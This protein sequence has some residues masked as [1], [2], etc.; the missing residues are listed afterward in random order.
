MC[1]LTQARVP[2][3]PSNSPACCLSESLSA[4]ANCTDHF[5]GCTSRF[6]THCRQVATER[7]LCTPQITSWVFILFS[8]Q[9]SLST[10]TCTCT[11]STAATVCA[12]NSLSQVSASDPA[13][14]R[15]QKQ[16]CASSSGRGAPTMWS[17]CPLPRAKTTLQA[18]PEEQTAM[19]TGGGT[20]TRQWSQSSV[21]TLAVSSSV[22]EL[23]QYQQ[24]RPNIQVVGAKLGKPCILWTGDLLH[25]KVWA[26]IR[27]HICCSCH[28][29]FA[30]L[31]AVEAWERPNWYTD[32]RL[33]STA[34]AKILRKRLET[35]GPQS[36]LPATSSQSQSCFL[37]PFLQLQQWALNQETIQDNDR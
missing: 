36:K 15:V 25:T 19:L 17:T 5:Q 4:R 1:L 37:D 34:A 3:I 30:L 31:G 2:C 11:P 18:A 21:R 13:P 20:T 24:D 33:S 27:K 6:W 23:Q 10:A 28:S 35:Y 29:P 22:Q 12:C 26:Q 32:R 14:C 8:S 9:L 7:T 16:C